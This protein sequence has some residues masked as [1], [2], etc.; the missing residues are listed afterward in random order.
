MMK[1]VGI[2]T[3]YTGYN[4]GSA[5]QAFATKNILKR[6]G[7]DGDIL[8]VSGSMVKGR[9][10]RLKK[11]IVLGW[12]ILLHP[13]CA[14]SVI[15]SYTRSKNKTL[16]ESSKR[17]FNEFYQKKI[18][19]TIIAQ[20]KL[21]SV[22]RSDEYLSFI[23]GSDQIWNASTLYVDPFYYL[24]FAP[25]E[26]RIAFAP[27]FGRDF[28]PKYNLK[29]IKKRISAIP[30]L[31]VRESGGQQIIKDLIG[32]DVQVLLDP[33]LLIDK[34]TWIELLQLKENK[35]EKPYVLAY[36][37]DEPSPKAKR[38]IGELANGGKE[39]VF[40]PYS[41]NEVWLDRCLD[42]GPKEFLQILL[43]AD[44]VCTDSFHGTAFSINFSKEFYCFEREKRG[45]AQFR[46][47]LSEKAV[48]NK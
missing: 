17:K 22:A 7:Y 27:S 30:N 20:S 48:G 32:K 24:S 8:K 37:L 19:P 1:K 36:F 5:L 39:V 25:R 15:C 46:T 28:I 43:N 45:L 34:E 35:P 14:K 29:K 38:I 13:M 47:F 18:N 6:L 2:C 11:L 41:R 9:D 33:T 16:S 26:K 12:N 3:V 44:V 4:Y 10:I 23:C 40:L 31:S 42:A 21:K